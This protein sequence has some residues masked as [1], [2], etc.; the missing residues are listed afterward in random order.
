MKRSVKERR[1]KSSPYD[2]VGTSSSFFGRQ[3]SREKYGRKEEDTLQEGEKMPSR[4]GIR[5]VADV[6]LRVCRRK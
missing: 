6:F 3:L 1:K 4:R 2:Y 5:R